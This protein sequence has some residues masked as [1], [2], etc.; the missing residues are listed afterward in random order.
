MSRLLMYASMP[1]TSTAFH[2][3]SRPDKSVRWTTGTGNSRNMVAD[4]AMGR[5]ESDE[6]A[7]TS[8]IDAVV[9]RYRRGHWLPS[10]LPLEAEKAFTGISS[11]KFR[12]NGTLYWS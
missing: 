12:P 10:K 9:R 8:E 5:T 7:R 2:D 11:D 1:S 3:G 4:G 6:M